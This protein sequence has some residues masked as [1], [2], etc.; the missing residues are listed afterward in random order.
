MSIIKWHPFGDFLNMY[1]RINRV[2]EDEFTGE[3]YKPGLPLSAWTP[4]TDIY[5]NKDGYVLKMELP[6]FSKN[7]VKIEFTNDMLIVKGERKQE[8]EVKKENFHRIERSFG[9]FQRSFAL[10]KNIDPKKIEANLNDGLLMLTIPKAE[11]AKTKAISI[12]V[13]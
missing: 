12:S 11:E 4:L 6:G 3:G 10:P 5:E 7:E 13:K 2:F 1:D 8:E 9:L